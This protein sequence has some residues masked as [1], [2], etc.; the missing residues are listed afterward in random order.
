MNSR[1]SM[2]SRSAGQAISC[3]FFVSLSLAM[4]SDASLTVILVKPTILIPRSFFP[5]PPRYTRKASLRR[6]APLHSG[7]VS[8]WKIPTIPNPLHSGHAPYGELNVKSLG[9]TSGNDDP[10]IGQM[11]FAE[12]VRSLPSGLSIFTSPFD[13]AS[14]SSTASERRS[15][16][17]LG[18]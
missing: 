18:S 17:F 6:R 11:N 13:C 5:S 12:S 10:S 1:R 14:A 4:K 16:E 15:R 8:F 7:Q 3:C 2:I 9:S